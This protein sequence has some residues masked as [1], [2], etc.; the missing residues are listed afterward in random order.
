MVPDRHSSQPGLLA[1][2]G[3][4]HHLQHPHVRPPSQEDPLQNTVHDVSS[5][6]DSDEREG[7]IRVGKDYQAVIPSFIPKN[8]KYAY[9]TAYDLM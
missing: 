9:N 6:E 7:R 2:G 3:D 5:G 1:S 4:H 8:R